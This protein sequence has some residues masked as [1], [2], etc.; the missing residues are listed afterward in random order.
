MCSACV[1]KRVNVGG[2][3]LLSFERSACKVDP[4]VACGNLGFGKVPTIA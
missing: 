4:W 2:L 3:R 1:Q